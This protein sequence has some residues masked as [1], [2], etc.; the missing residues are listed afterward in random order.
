MLPPTRPLSRRSQRVDVGAPAG[1]RCCA[2]AACAR[3]RSP[4]IADGDATLALLDEKQRR[5]WLSPNASITSMASPLPAAGPGRRRGTLDGPRGPG[6]DVVAHAARRQEEAASERRRACRTAW[7]PHNFLPPPPARPP[8]AGRP[9]RNCA[10]SA[11]SG[12][13]WRLRAS[14]GR[15]PRRDFEVELIGPVR[16]A[17]FRRVRAPARRSRRRPAGALLS[18][19][20]RAA[21]AL[22]RRRIQPRRHP[23]QDL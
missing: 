1:S 20:R 13:R 11:R 12:A 16:G 19:V 23:G 15:W 17:P 14:A 18:G 7:D 21:A 6:A 2:G 4:S 8:R 10:T 5:R 3:A 9:A 22:R